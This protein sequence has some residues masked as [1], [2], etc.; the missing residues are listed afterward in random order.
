[1]Q[2]FGNLKVE[3][4]VSDP[5]VPFKETISEI[6][7]LQCSAETPGNDDEMRTRLVMVAEPLEESVLN[8]LDERELEQHDNN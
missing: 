4:K 2:G 5:V 3:V 1:M 6:S 7:V 8:A